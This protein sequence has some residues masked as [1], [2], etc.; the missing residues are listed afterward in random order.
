MS[1][2]L[3]VLPSAAVAYYQSGHMPDVRGLPRPEPLYLNLYR[4]DGDERVHVEAFVRDRFM[5]THHA[6]IKHYHPYLLSLE[7]AA[8]TVLATAGF[9]PACNADLFL[10]QYLDNP[11]EVL[12][13]G[14][15]SRDI[16]RA[17][18]IEVGNLAS[19]CPGSSRLLIMAMTWLFQMHNLEWVVMTGTHDLM[20]V[21]KNL[22]L[23]PA[24]IT[25]A[26]AC[27]LGEHQH[28]WG[29]YY[30]KRAYVMAGNI[31]DGHQR[32]LQSRAYHNFIQSLESIQFSKCGQRGVSA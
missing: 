15:F 20:N 12:L 14:L 11:V 29:H 23:E 27:R 3:A 22:D 6:D 17:S 31:L 28:D 13:S 7:T 1:I 30:D 32:L 21:F 8:G 24:M 26:R 19:D 9:R 2:N 25:E 5:V 18:I 10:E 16:D 4:P